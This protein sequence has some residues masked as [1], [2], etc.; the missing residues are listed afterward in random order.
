MVIIMAKKEFTY[1]GKRM[2]ELLAMDTAA[3]AELVTA[4]ARRSLLR[5]ENK[6]L[7]AKVDKAKAELDSGKFPKP[8]R[9][10]RRDT[11]VIPKMVG[12]RMAVYKGNEFVNV[13]IK[14]EMLGH[15]LGEFAL[16]RK[17]VTHGKAGI[18]AT[19]SSTAI[20]ARK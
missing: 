20:A 5:N 13:D 16:T 14:P 19:R 7:L 1:R 15:Y 8:V 11:I 12:L 4:R 18:G 9:T 3:F 6:H 17:R 2:E 10:H